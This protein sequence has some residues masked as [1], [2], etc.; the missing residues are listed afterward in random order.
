MAYIIGPAG[1]T[2][3]TTRRPRMLRLIT[4]F[5]EGTCFHP[6]KY[7]PE[8]AVKFESWRHVFSDVRACRSVS[9]AWGR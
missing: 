3:S 8:Y 2:T 4:E 5:R 6:T 9:C 7:A 1:P